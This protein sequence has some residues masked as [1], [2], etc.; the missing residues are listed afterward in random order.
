MLKK[1]FVINY[2]IIDI[3]KMEGE[4]RM[5]QKLKSH[6]LVGGAF[7][8]CLGLSLSWQNRDDAAES[9]KVN[10]QLAVEKNTVNNLI[11]SLNYDPLKILSFQ[12]DSISNLPNTQ[13]VWKNGVFY[14]MEKKMKSLSSGTADISYLSAGEGTLYPGAVYLANRDLAEGR[15]T[16]VPA[17]KKGLKLTI[18]LPGLT[19]TD[20]QRYVDKPDGGNTQSAI[21]DMIDVWIKKYPQYKQV[22][23]KVEYEQAQTYS[24]SQLEAQLGLGV[25]LVS[26]KLNVDFSAISKGEKQCIFLKFKQIYYTVNTNAKAT[27]EQ[28]FSDNVTPE[29]LQRQGVSNEAPPVFVSSVSY[30]R[31]VYA[32]IETSNTSNKFKLA[33][34][35]AVNGKDV[36]ANVELNNLI[37]ESTFN[38]IVYGGGTNSGVK[39]INGTLDSIHEL[40]DEGK[41]FDRNTPAVPISFSTVFMKDNAQALVKNSTD[42][43]ETTVK[44]CHSGEIDLNHSGAYIARYYIDWDEISYDD[45]GNELKNRVSWQENDM[46]KTAG[47]SSQIPIPA[48]ARNINIKIKECTGL[49]WDWWHVVYDKKNLPNVS[50]RNISIWGTTLS[51]YYNDI[52]N[53]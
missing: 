52:V 15:P 36:T 9:K 33:V 53:Q 42:Y 8:A 50:K 16:V 45:K 46:D 17:E 10:K 24:M 2:N 34:D 30:G 13:S 18:D 28:Y 25:N 11:Y 23:A 43:V 22:P 20:N 49:A 51:P 26:Q 39:V 47:F 35:A 40:I 27:P 6:L 41:N 1:V 44:E 21:N 32:A 5:N 4:I 7:L 38:A 37:K 29:E 12:G 31:T 14:V 19:G 48:N 3:E